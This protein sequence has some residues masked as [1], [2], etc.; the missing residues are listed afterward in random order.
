LGT[1]SAVV[2]PF[3]FLA[4]AYHY[5]ESLLMPSQIADGFSTFA[6]PVTKPKRVE[7][8]QAALQG[9]HDK[10]ATM[11]S[12]G[13]APEEIAERLEFEDGVPRQDTLALIQRLEAAMQKR[14]GVA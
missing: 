7:D 12:N 14:G 8:P 10:L 5:L 9:L 1:I 3:L 6:T 4:N 11:M 13:M 2:T